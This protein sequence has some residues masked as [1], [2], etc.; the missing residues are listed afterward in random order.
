MRGLVL[1][2]LPIVLFGFSLTWHY[3]LGQS[4][5]RDVPLLSVSE[6]PHLGEMETSG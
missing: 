4:V 6:N 5:T 3:G 1:P 2:T